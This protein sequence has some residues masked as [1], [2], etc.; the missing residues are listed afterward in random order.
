M[1]YS[2]TLKGRYFNIVGHFFSVY[3]IYKIFM[4]SCCDYVPLHWYCYW[5]YCMVII[6]T[7]HGQYPPQSCRES[8]WVLTHHKGAC[9]V[10]YVHTYVC[11][12]IHIEVGINLF[13]TQV[14]CEWLSILFHCRPRHKRHWDYRQ[15]PR[16]QHRRECKPHPQ[17][18]HAAHCVHGALVLYVTQYILIKGA[19]GSRSD[20]T[21]SMHDLWPQQGVL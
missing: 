20:R 7:V 14:P 9:M 1:A 4:V 11:K 2:K 6:F 10:Y 16:L 17:K 12:Y 15:V 13:W 8:G 5:L 3:C 21:D 19:G 18:P